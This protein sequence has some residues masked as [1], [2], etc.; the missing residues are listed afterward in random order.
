VVEDVA[1]LV[2]ADVRVDQPQLAVLHQ[3]ISVFQLR[4]S[5]PRS[6]IPVSNFSRKK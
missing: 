4:T 2:R 6:M 5:V 1:M 3:A